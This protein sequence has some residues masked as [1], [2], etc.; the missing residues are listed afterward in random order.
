LVPSR[1]RG[2]LS[3]FFETNFAH[4]RSNL[5]DQTGASVASESS[6]ERGRLSLAYGTNLYP[7][8]TLRLGGIAE[9][10]L[11]DSKV[12]GEGTESQTVRLSPNADLTFG[13]PMVHGGLGYNRQQEK[14]STGAA[15]TP[16]RV[17]ENFQG[18]LG[19]RPEDLPALELQVL[20][21]NNFDA[22]R[23]LQDNRVDHASWSSRYSPFSG[24]DLGYQ[25]SR[26][27]SQ[28]FLKDL[29]TINLANN[30]RVNY[31]TQFLNGRVNLSTSYNLSRQD[32]ETRAQGSGD[33]SFSVPAL[34]GFSSLDATPLEGALDVNRA[35]VDG[36]TAVS[37]GVNL[38]APPVGGDRTP[39]NLGLDFGLPSDV[40]ALRVLLSRDIPA[41]VASSL[42]WEVYTSADNATWA[43]HQ[44]VSGAPFRL[45]EDGVN[46]FEIRFA[47]VSARFVKLVVSPLSRATPG[48]LDIAELFVT[49]LQ[50]FLIR[51]AQEVAGKTTRT[52]QTYDLSLRALLLEDPSLSYDF[53]FFYAGASPG[54][55]ARHS[56][57]N[58]LSAARRFSRFLSGGTRLSREDSV[59]PIRSSSAYTL[60]TSLQATPLETLTNS[61]VFSGRLENAEA[62]STRSESL[63]LNNAAALY[64]GVDVSLSGGVSR[65]SRRGGQEITSATW[66]AGATL[67]P[68][69]K[70]TV[71]LAYFESLSDQSGGVKKTSTQ[72]VRQE[73]ASVAFSPLSALYLFASL[74]ITSSTDRA[75]SATQSYSVGWSPFREGALQF[76]VAYAESLRSEDNGRDKAFTPSVRWNIGRKMNLDLSYQ[77]SETDSASQSST[78]ETYS[79]NL[80][81]SF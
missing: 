34:S 41:N 62:E 1:A 81:A 65:S 66:N 19:L 70:M 76:S 5:E 61:L 60:S 75:A 53:A 27:R 29:E 13:N 51:P 78:T 42:S 37:S 3:G 23:E 25:G 18:S 80:R 24:L 64:R 47:S 40:N 35:L 67:V 2:E 4:S 11:S 63:F 45:F 58:G 55:A 14:Q 71:N 20:R 17:R 50:A 9:G 39:R 33:V 10:T 8:T 46:G 59:D 48:T 73:S 56:V 38:G 43:L 36:D 74:S 26:D 12:A 72:R 79:A 54:G 57:T 52:S 77:R 15:S 30:G 28:D 31:G 7:S 6:T 32:I 16:A 49:E 22:G 21:T 69:S 68:N 44:T